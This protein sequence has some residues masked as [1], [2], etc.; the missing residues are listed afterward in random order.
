M[1]H[2]KCKCDGY[3][4]NSTPTSGAG[5]CAG[6]GGDGGS[7]TPVQDKHAASIYA[8]SSLFVLAAASH[9]EQSVAAT[10]LLIFD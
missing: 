9:E 10:I 2:C 3:S 7:R 1:G 6:S 8:C 5:G 4:R